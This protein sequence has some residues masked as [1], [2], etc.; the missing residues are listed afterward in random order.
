MLS[1]A[2]LRQ[3]RHKGLYCRALVGT[4]PLQLRHKGLYW[5]DWFPTAVPVVVVDAASIALLLAGASVPL[6]SAASMLLLL[7]LLLFALPCQVWPRTRLRH[8]GH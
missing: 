2:R 7:L 4:L 3:L 6:D 5:I 8:K 1:V